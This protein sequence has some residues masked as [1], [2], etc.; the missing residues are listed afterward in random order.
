MNKAR[1]TDVEVI[2]ALRDDCS[3]RNRARQQFSSWSAKIEQAWQ[4]RKPLSP[5][6]LRRMEF[7]AVDEI[8]A[9]LRLKP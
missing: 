7:E 3:T 6:E 1:M 9:A 2:A 5:I 8:A 4:Q